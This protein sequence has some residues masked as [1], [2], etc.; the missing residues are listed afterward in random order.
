MTDDSAPEDDVIGSTEPIDADFEPA[1]EDSSGTGRRASGGPGWLGA[2]VLSLFAAGLGGILFDVGDEVWGQVWGQ[3]W[4][5]FGARFGI[6]G[7][8]PQ[9]TTQTTIRQLV[10]YTFVEGAATLRQP[11]DNPQTTLRQ[12]SDNP[13][14]PN[15][16]A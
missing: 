12:P 4:A 16:R 8:K 1:P 5:R 11:P 15:L 7:A 10:V 6:K 9:T 2:L 13:R 3:V 14:Q